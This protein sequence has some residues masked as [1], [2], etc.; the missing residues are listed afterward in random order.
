VRCQLKGPL[1]GDAARSLAVLATP[2]RQ[3]AEFFGG[4]RD[5]Q[6]IELRLLL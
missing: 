2:D 5:R 6:P 3:V 1:F 4:A